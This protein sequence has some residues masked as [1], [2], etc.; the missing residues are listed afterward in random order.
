MARSGAIVCAAALLA[1]GVACAPVDPWTE[2]PLSTDAG[3]RDIFFLDDQRGWTVGGGYP[4]EG[5]I[6]GRTT[7]GGRSWSFESGLAGRS[8][9]KQNVQL[10]AV[11][12]LDDRKGFIVASDGRILRTVDGGEHWHTAYHAGRFLL[13]LHFVDERHGWAVG[14]SGVL[15]TTDGG[16]TWEP[17]QRTEEEP[18]VTG[19]AVRFLDRELGWVVGSNGS[20][21]H[22]ADG[23]N[24]WRRLRQAQSGE[25][26]FEALCFVDAHRGWVAGED[27]VVLHSVD[28]GWT[29][30]RQITATHAYLTGIHFFDRQTGWAVGYRRD[31]ST[32]V[33]LHTTNGGTTWTHHRRVEGQALQALAFVGREHGWAVG[34]RIRPHSQ[35]VLRYEAPRTD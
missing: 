9:R 14:S 2:Q 20:I 22:T 10:H 1:C 31:N 24:S 29:W 25:P 21:H 28:G 4:V 35:R 15:R 6:V 18:Q 32:S 13:D 17:Q 7:D 19:R 30:S 26:N 34:G 33:L 16:A 8:K 27:G 12:F 11:R 23:G 5:G 3:L